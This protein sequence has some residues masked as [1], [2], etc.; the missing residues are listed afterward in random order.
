MPP[1][2]FRLEQVLAYRRQLEDQAM[3]ALSRAVMERDALAGRLQDLEREQ[4]ELL[5]MLSRPDLLEAG[6]RAQALD[7]RLA[8]KSD[9]D[10]IRQALDEA[11]A[12][13]DERRADLV[14]RSKERGLLDSLK[15]KQADRHLRSERQ[16]EQ[17]NNDETATLRYKPAAF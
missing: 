6:E 2:R 5:L 9:L 11:E 3:L 10:Y 13:V 4:R 17:R 1:F 15:E 7:Y 16:Q 12:L 14:E 8:L